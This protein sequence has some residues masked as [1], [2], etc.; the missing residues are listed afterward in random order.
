MER[1][2][3]MAATALQVVFGCAALVA[4]C[5]AVLAFRR[6]HRTPAA[7]AL[8]ATMAGVALWSAIDAA[9]LLV[10]SD[11]LRR[12]YPPVL[13]AAV[14]LAVIGTYATARTVSDPSWRATSR[15]KLLGAV[16][17]ALV[18]LAA[19][20]PATR[21]LVMSDIPPGPVG[22]EARVTLGPLFLAATAYNYV[23]VGVAYGTLAR[24]WLRATGVFRRQIG[25][26]L[27]S[28]A[29]SSLGS[30]VAVLTQLDGHGTDPTP[31]FLLVTGLVDCWAIF[32][33][34]LLRMVPVAREQVVDTVP[35][36]VLVVDPTG[37]VI[38]VNPAA[39]RMLHRLRPELAGDLVG[40]PLAD[41]AG[42][43]AVAVLGQAENRDGHRLAE[44]VPGLWLDVRDS[45][46]S[47]PRGRPLGRI[48][49]VRDVSE[50]QERQ[51]AVERLNR[52]L[53]DQV[54]V[55]ERLRAE[56][57]E[58][59]VRDPL[60]GLH[61]RRHLDRALAADLARRPRTGELSLLVVDI[62]HFKSINDRHGHAAG[63]AVLTSV[64]A[65]LSAAVRDGDT[66]ARLGGEEFVLVLPGAGPEAA[67][68]RA[69]QV[70]R[71]VTVVR[72]LLD[73]ADVGVTVSVGL[74]V[75]PADGSSPAA[76]LAAADQALYT[77]KAS[78]RDRVVAAVPRDGGAVPVRERVPGG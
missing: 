31:L 44:V 66:A 58:E 72:H 12:A 67:L 71:D 1:G 34:G 17:P 22:A 42:P 70:R 64:A 5:T 60:T 53:A 10:E 41:V 73:G 28:A 29:F 8:A 16:V 52:Q 13:L 18:V 25:V 2:A 6:R 65:T 32:R 77:A 39:A 36:A 38:D 43:R 3:G 45:A 56:L 62:D 59:A 54:E 33:V 46:V 40:R 50:Q 57:A 14:S 49:V 19:V 35:D 23:L 26:L 11:V 63:D 74:A 55:I 20:L 48:L 78:G 51:A 75:C 21:G 68:E 76:L 9:V 15:T 47:D 24:R 37:L 69:E 7:T 61:N 4:V 30:V 27:G